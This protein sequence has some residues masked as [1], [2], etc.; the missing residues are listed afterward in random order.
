MR[1]LVPLEVLTALVYAYLGLSLPWTN[2]VA[3]V[4]GLQF[5]IVV[6]GALV[7]GWGAWRGVRWTP[8]LAI[9]LAAFAGIPN[10]TILAALV[11]LTLRAAGP[12]VTLS[13]G[14]V[15]LA[16]ICQLAALLIA[17]R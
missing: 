9:A 13:F 12:A 11:Q 1:T 6:A 2:S 17:L 16:A 15:L 8:K 5:V 7:I 14:L 4:R 10:F 3:I